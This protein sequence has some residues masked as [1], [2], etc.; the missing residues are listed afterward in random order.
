[1]PQTPNYSLPYPAIS[2]PPNGPAQIS[3][4]AS[5]VDSTILAVYNTLATAMDTKRHKVLPEPAQ[6][7]TGT[8]ASGATL[9]LASIAIAD[10]GWPYRITTSG[11]ILWSL[12]A[13]AT[14]PA[15]VGLEVRADVNAWSDT[16]YLSKGIHPVFIASNFSLPAG[17]PTRTP[18]TVYTGPHTL[19]LIAKNLAGGPAV[20]GTDGYAFHVA[21]T[22]T[23]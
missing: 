3:A 5:G 7:G 1:M 14:V 4:L 21:I 13:S 2:D 18:P 12:G 23:P 8:L 6:T 19:Y 15:S 9:T 11:A 22:P 20:L 16:L 17:C 10:P